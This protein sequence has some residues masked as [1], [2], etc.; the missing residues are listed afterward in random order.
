MNGM[1]DVGGMDGF[2]PIIREKNEPFFHTDWERRIYAI[3]SAIPYPLNYGDDQFRREIERIP[4]AQYLNASYYELWFYS[5]L[6]LLEEHNVLS[7]GD[8]DTHA[9]GEPATEFVEGV[10]R[11]KEVAATI[12]AGASTRADIAEV[13]Q[14]FAVGDRVRV[15]NNHP[16]H[17]HRAPRYIRSLVGKIVIDHG[18]F[19]FA[20]SNS[21]YRGDCPQHVYAVEFSGRELW[22]EDAEEGTSVT[23]DLFETYVEAP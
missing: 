2:G 22:G 15:K 12:L 18:V 17:H 20:D 8:L 14:A 16:Y 11:V 19:N 4:P 10:V 7:K 1:H 3:A 13:P 9:P 6:S 23:I 5:T 21:E